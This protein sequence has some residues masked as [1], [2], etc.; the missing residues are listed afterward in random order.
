[1]SKPFIP[2]LF[3]A[4]R[5]S[6][7]YYGT[8]KE[9]GRLTGVNAESV[10]KASRRLTNTTLT[11]WTITRVLREDAPPG[12]RNMAA[13]HYIAKRDGEDPI[14]GVAEEIASLIDAEVSLVRRAANAGRLA[15]GWHIRKASEE[16]V[17]EFE[18]QWA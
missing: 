4:R 17:E 6:E 3:R 1:M 13:Q 8:A 15:K 9:I 14:M 5:G 7:T 2:N 10:A 18:R 11:G 12:Y 16:E